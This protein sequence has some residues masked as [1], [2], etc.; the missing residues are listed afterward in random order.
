MA[1]SAALRDEI[2]HHPQLERFAADLWRRTQEFLDA[3]LGDRDSEIRRGLERQLVA[4]GASLATEPE[5]GGRLNDWLRELIVYIVE[6][7]RDPISQII[8]A[9]IAEWD[10]TAT[11]RRIELQIGSDLQ[12][13]R[14]NGT[15]VG[16]LVGV[17]LYALWSS[18][19]P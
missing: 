8:S 7:Y 9:T 2:L 13:I 11:A 5:I 19:V 12:F 17:L 10:A 4:V 18:L 14:I 3:S 1:K 16:G 6:N 15:L